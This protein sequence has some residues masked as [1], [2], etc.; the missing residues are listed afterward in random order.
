MTKT[1][2]KQNITKIN[3]LLRSDSYEAGIELIKTLDDPEITKGTAKAVAAFIKD[4]ISPKKDDSGT[5]VC[6]EK[7]INTAIEYLKSFDESEIFE[8]ILKGCS[9][10]DDGYKRSSFFKGS[11]WTQLLLDYAF[12]NIL[13]LVPASAN[14]D[15][16]LKP[17]NIKRL[18]IKSVRTI[19]HEIKAFCNLNSLTINGS[20][21]Y[22]G[23]K[24]SLE[25]LPDEISQLKKITTLDLSNNKL[26][27]ISPH[28]LKIKN[29]ESLNLSE[30]EIKSLPKE[31]E[32]LTNL[33]SLN[34]YKNYLTSIPE[35]IGRLTKLKSLNLEEN[36]ITSLPSDIFLLQ[37]TDINL[38][39][40]FNS[41]YTAVD[42]WIESL[43]S[44][45]YSL[46]LQNYSIQNGLVE[47]G[48]DTGFMIDNM[49]VLLKLIL[50]CPEKSQ[51]D[52]S[53][54]CDNITYLDLSENNFEVLP[55][56]IGKLSNLTE[57][58][59]ESNSLNDLHGEIGQLKN[60]ECLNLSKNKWKK[61]PDV[62]NQLQSLKTLEL[63]GNP[64]LPV[65]NFTQL[66][67]S[68]NKLINLENLNLTDHNFND[69]GEKR[70]KELLPN[71]EITF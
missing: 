27:S 32:Q 64:Y 47:K 40:N 58:N 8:I 57:L 52:E 68:I 65:W 7:S 36:D 4:L 35:E 20:D 11:D 54:H 19:P 67:E 3:K 45:N 25:S 44:E 17:K 14:V 9:I 6:D 18:V 59:L 61:Y 62:I 23:D 42:K 38:R 22:Y 51:I 1:E 15:D 60:L 41:D 56:E 34:C 66:P 21:N 2:V 31:I 29:L 48:V 12:F 24:I 53:L 71:T 43:K 55:S 5:L 16:S 26:S 28:L 13:F 30:N 69:A 70:I 37:N 50:Q 39:M 49:Y 46:L 63:T 33:Q 10:T